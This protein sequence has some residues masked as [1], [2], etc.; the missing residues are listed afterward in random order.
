M[1]NWNNIWQ[2]SFP[3]F[4]EEFSL[5]MTHHILFDSF[6]CWKIANLHL[7]IFF[8]IILSSSLNHCY[9]NYL[10]LTIWILFLHEYAWCVICNIKNQLIFFF[11]MLNNVIFGLLPL[12]SSTII[13]QMIPSIKYIHFLLTYPY[14]CY[15]YLL[16]FYYLLELHL[17]CLKNII[18]VNIHLK[19]L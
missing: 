10:R 19:I 3:L 18:L 5:S 14:Y 12:T 1:K 17:I 9:P 8:A 15:L 4:L 11:I 16:N 13:D 6:S 2:F 7:F